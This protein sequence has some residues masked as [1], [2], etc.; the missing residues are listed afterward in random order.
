MSVFERMGRGQPQMT[1]QDALQRLQ[2]DPAAAIREAKL[3]IPESMMGNPQQM[4]MHL[5]Q[6]GQVSSPV[7]QRVMP[8]I[9][10]LMGK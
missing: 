6:T 3:N 5:I 1:F 2:R 7:L 10:R 8:M 4:A 9:N